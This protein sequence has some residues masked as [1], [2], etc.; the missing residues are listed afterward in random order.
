MKKWLVI[1]IIIVV[2]IIGV[3]AYSQCARPPDPDKPIGGVYNGRVIAQGQDPTGR[4]T[5]FFEGKA[6]LQVLGFYQLKVGSVYTVE[7][8]ETKDGLVVKNIILVGE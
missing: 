1:V 7:T 6:P 8:K 2:L 5:I 4:T 3:F